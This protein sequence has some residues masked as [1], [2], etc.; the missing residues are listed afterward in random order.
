MLSSD[1]QAKLMLQPLLKQGAKQTPPNRFSFSVFIH[2]LLFFFFII[3][4]NFE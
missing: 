3:E 4:T 1:H 2:S